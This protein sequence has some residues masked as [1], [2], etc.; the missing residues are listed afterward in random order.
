MVV[1]GAL[2]EVTFLVGGRAAVS[3]FLVNELF[4]IWRGARMTMEGH[5]GKRGKDVLYLRSDVRLS[6]RCQVGH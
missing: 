5:L 1:G 6:L 4:K 3:V 2:E